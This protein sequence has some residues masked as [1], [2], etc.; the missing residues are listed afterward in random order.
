MER[1]WKK[2]NL[3]NKAFKI[4]GPLITYW[5]SYHILFIIDHSI[6]SKNMCALIMSLLEYPNNTQEYI[7]P[8]HDPCLWNPRTELSTKFPPSLWARPYTSLSRR[9]LY[10]CMICFVQEL[11]WAMYKIYI[12]YMGFW[13]VMSC[14]WGVGTAIST[15]F[16]LYLYQG[17]GGFWSS[18][19][20]NRI[21][22][23][24]L[25]FIH[26]TKDTYDCKCCF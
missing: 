4:F 22:L 25:L 26:W 18:E 20:C 14:T 9:S 24:T 6:Q 2:T 13:D 8:P 10:N 7:F 23:Y 12:M 11:S 3:E 21:M 17:R 1:K 19:M 5:N 15:N 16:P